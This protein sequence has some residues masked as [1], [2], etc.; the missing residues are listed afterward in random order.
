MTARKDR[1]APQ[2]QMARWDLKAHRVRRVIPVARKVRPVL[3]V[4]MEMMALQVRKAR[5]AK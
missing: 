1:Q 4:R 3:R 2:E 5:P